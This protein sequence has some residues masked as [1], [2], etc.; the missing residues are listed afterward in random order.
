MSRAADNLTQERIQQLLAAVGV[1]A[2]EDAG[3]NVDALEYNWREPHFF[4]KDQLERLDGF[5]ERVA[6]SCTEKFTQLYHSDFNVTITLVKQHFASDLKVSD[7][8]QRDCYLAF[9]ADPDQPFGLV[10]IPYRTAIFWATQLLG[11]TKSAEDADRDLSQLEE[12]L[13]FDIACGVVQA[14]SDSYA[15]CDLHPGSEIVRNQMPIELDGTE[16][17]LKITFS[18]E[19]TDLERSSEAYFLVLCNKLR[20]VVAQDIQTSEALSAQDISNAMLNHIQDLPVSVTA[21]LAH[22]TS[23]FQ[24]I[25]NLQVGD[26]LLLD[27]EVDE[28]TELIVEGKTVLR[29]RPA[30]SD[31]Q[32]AVVIT[33]LCNAK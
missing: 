28:P 5:A 12:S 27:K 10:G 31:G 22:A 17:L 19:K 14:F 25:M 32:Y 26:I 20:P 9:N 15:L 24:E 29:G 6:Q 1:E 33:E 11:D 3:H 7:E 2:Q 13:L 16:E 4:S 21:Q 18:V 23:S 30:Q 8:S